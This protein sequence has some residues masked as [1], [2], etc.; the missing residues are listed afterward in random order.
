LGH[1]SIRTTALCWK[2]IYQDPNNEVSPILA[3]KKWLE[4]KEQPP[5]TENFPETL[6]TTKPLFIEQ[7]PLIPSK[8]PIHQDNSL[9]TLKTIKKTPQISIN[10]IS[11]ERQAKFF[12][13][14]A[15]KK[16]DQ[17]KTTQPL[18]LIANQD[19][20]STEKELILLQKVKQ[21]EEQLKQ[22]KAEN[23]KLKFEKEKAEALAQQEKQRANNYQQQLK[24]IVR[25][26]KQ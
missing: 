1:S 11:P 5:S 2:N 21:L 13:N 19:Q 14:N 22:V 4:S 6:E 25:T 18:P 15:D 24:V 8:E 16:N 10:P 20:N 7:K 9:S 3:G 23:K 17:L 12:L 26:L